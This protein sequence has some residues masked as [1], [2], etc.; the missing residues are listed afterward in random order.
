MYGKVFR[1]IKPKVDY[2]EILAHT[3]Q[4]ELWSWFLGFRV[5]SGFRFCNPLRSDSHP[6]VW[7]D[8]SW[9]GKDI[10]VLYDW[11]DKF[12]HGMSIFDAV[13]YREKLEFYDAVV[14]VFKNYHKGK[15]PN[16]RFINQVK[17]EFNFYLNYIPWTVDNRIS[18]INSDKLFWSP[19]GITENNLREDRVASCRE[20]LFNSRQSPTILNRLSTTPSYAIHVNNHVKI[21]NPYHK[22]KWLSTCTEEDIGGISRL[23]NEDSIIIT[24]S[25]KDWRVLINAGYN[26]VWLQNE[27]CKIPFDK[28]IKFQQFKT[29]FILFDNDNAGIKA[30]QELAEYGNNFDKGYVPVWYENDQIKDSADIMK[31]YGEQAL[32]TEL[33]NLGIK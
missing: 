11:A 22:M 10:V 4:F 16:K 28:L 5:T 32:T 6:N 15:L 8:T 17:T 2:K 29:K 1:D 23:K 21:Y 31:Q 25:Y 12:F 24:K 13:M 33:L 19:Y 14:Y 20:I 26:S 7:V 30:S 18:Y 3:D 9:T 27:G